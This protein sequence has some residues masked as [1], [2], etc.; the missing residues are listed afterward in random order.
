MEEQRLELERRHSLDMEKLLDNVN[1]KLI[2]NQFALSVY[3]VC[4][5]PTE[6]ILIPHHTVY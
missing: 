3:M 6:V 5:A 2:I 1:K 4:T